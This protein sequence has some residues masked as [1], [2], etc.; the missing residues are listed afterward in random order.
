[1]PIF[2]G[3]SRTQRN[4]ILRTIIRNAKNAFEKAT[5]SF[6]LFSII[7]TAKLKIKILPWG[8]ALRFVEYRFIKCIPLIGCIENILLNDF[9]EK[10]TI[11]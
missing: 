2:P 9:L 11:F 1:M 4:A 7:A 6:Y 5:P 10:K 3:L 8:C